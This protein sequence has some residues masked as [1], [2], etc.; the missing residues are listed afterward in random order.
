MP[1]AITPPGSPGMET[2]SSSFAMERYLDLQSQ[3]EELRKNL[4][5]IRSSAPVGSLTSHTSL[6]SS[7]SVSP[8]RRPCSPF[9]HYPAGRQH[10]RSSGASPHKMR[11]ASG[12]VLP[13]VADESILYQLADEERRLFDINE[14]MKRAL[15]EMLNGTQAKGDAAFRTWVQ[16]RLMDT[17]KELRSERRR[18]SAP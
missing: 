14:G 9:G 4:D 10:R 5:F 3:H 16:C 8:T 17:E 11:R 2:Q 15:M 6:N 12:A 13:P 1:V 7:P 18:K